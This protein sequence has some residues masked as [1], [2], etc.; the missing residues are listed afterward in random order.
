MTA[1]VD[2]ARKLDFGQFK[3]AVDRL[4]GIDEIAAAFED[5][6]VRDKAEF[7]ALSLAVL[8]DGEERRIVAVLEN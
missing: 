7:E 1:K 2:G 4:E 6:T 8:A 5:L 3:R